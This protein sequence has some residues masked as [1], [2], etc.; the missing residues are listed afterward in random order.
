MPPIRSNRKESQGK[1]GHYSAPHSK[2]KARPRK[3]HL[4]DEFKPNKAGHEYGDNCILSSIV[5]QYL[6]QMIRNAKEV[7]IDYDLAVAFFLDETSHMNL[8]DI[9]KSVDTIIHDYEILPAIT[10]RQHD[11]LTCALHIRKIIESFL[12]E[13]G[14][15]RP[16]ALRYPNIKALNQLIK[17][18]SKDPRALCSDK[19]VIVVDLAGRLL[20]INLPPRSKGSSNTPVLLDAI[21]KTQDGE[22]KTQEMSSEERA[23]KAYAPSTSVP[24]Q[25]RFS[26]S[27]NWPVP[28]PGAV[29]G[30]LPYQAFGYPLGWP[31]ALHDTKMKLGLERQG[32]TLD[33]VGERPTSD[34]YLPVIMGLGEETVFKRIENARLLE[35]EHW[36]YEVSRA[37]NAAVQPDTYQV[38][39]HVVNFIQENCGAM[40]SKRIKSLHNKIVQGQ[41]IHYNLQVGSHRDSKNSNLLDSVFYYGKGFTGGR[42]V[43]GA[44]GISVCGNPGYSTHGR[45]KFLDHSVTPI[46][47][48]SVAT[49]PLC[50]SLALYSH[51]DVY[52][53]PARVSGARKGK[54]YFSDPEMWLPFPP[55]DFSIDTCCKILRKHENQWQKDHSHHK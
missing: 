3:P 26:K 50:I 44:L 23:L 36:P 2:T 33:D 15:D 32:Y 12:T 27:K 35:E 43:F 42:M 46:L 24:I 41:Q 1:S 55:T 11:L 18:R 37:L 9:P 47:A 19:A 14:S 40:L 29:Y 28:I 6:R 30:L 22:K 48:K 34:C 53:G 31:E 8:P 39:E 21:E 13:P 51:A 20:L 17:D 16:F 52:S 54:G 5:D 49:P 25:S 4:D 45:F 38:A 7:V 10:S